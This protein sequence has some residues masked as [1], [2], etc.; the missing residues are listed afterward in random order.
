M[1]NKRSHPA[2]H[3][4]FAPGLAGTL[5]WMRYWTTSRSE[6]ARRALRHHWRSHL[7]PTLT[8]HTAALKGRV[9]GP[10][11]RADGAA[12]PHS[13]ESLA[14]AVRQRGWMDAHG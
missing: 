1:P 12:A 11:Y 13:Y 2:D 9:T 6:N 14:D 10:F 8:G 5:R 7:R 4:H 3:V